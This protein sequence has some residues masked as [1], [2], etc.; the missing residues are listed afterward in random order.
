MMNIS[1]VQPTRCQKLQ[2]Q[3]FRSFKVQK[4]NFSFPDFSQ[5]FSIFPD[6]SQT[7]LEFPDFSRFSRWVATLHRA[8]LTGDQFQHAV[9]YWCSTEPC[10][11]ATSSR[12]VTTRTS[13]S[14]HNTHQVVRVMSQHAPARHVTTRTSASCHNTHQVVRVMSQHAPARHVTTRTRWCVS[15]HK[16]WQVTVTAVSLC[17]D[18]LCGNLPYDLWSTDNTSCWMHSRTNSKHFCLTLIC[19]CCILDTSAVVNTLLCLM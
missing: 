4:A 11:P 18:Q 5:T 8:M 1:K 9:Y 13:A 2:L 3:L 7:T 14:R 17:V 19:I 6:F 15:C 12:N 10:W 16:W